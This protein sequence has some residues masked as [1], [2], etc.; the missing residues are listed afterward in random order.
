MYQQRRILII[1]SICG[2]II[3]TVLHHE[4]FNCKPKGLRN[5]VYRFCKNV[6][7]QVV[8]I[9]YTIFPFINVGSI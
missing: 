1:K 5:L 8:K 4:N 2:L 7:D 9:V 6:T 3:I